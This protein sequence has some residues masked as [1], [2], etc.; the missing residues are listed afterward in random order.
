VIALESV[1]RVWGS[2]AVVDRLTL[3][4]EA[5]E[6]LAIVG[7]SG[8]GKTTT[9]KMINRLIE[10]S[11]GRIL[12]DGADTRTLA[13]HELRRRIGY[14]FQEVGLFPHLTVAENV[15]VTPELLGWAEGRVRARVSEL[16]ALVE[17]DAAIGAR[18]PHELSGG[19][20]QRVGVAR[21]LAASPRALLLD[22]PFGALDPATR[23][24]LQDALA[25][26]HENLGLTTVLV[27]HDMAEALSL[28][29]RIA[30]LR[31]GRLVQVA[32][33]RELLRSPA[34]AAVASLLDAPNRAAELVKELTGPTEQREDGATEQ[35]SR[36]RRGRGGRGE[37]DA[38]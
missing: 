4:I 21:A 6:L 24:R 37:G 36:P 5:G 27:T 23:A 17:L 25:R 13:P 11:D 12:F 20:Q 16:L 22:E 1:T 26:I 28:A 34:D 33:P 32:S 14:A 31:D 2:I 18:M 19:Q 8:S 15:A 35:A 29:D 30:V 38:P 10:P 3:T 9:L 7:G